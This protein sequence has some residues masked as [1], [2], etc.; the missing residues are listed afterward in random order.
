M[1]A[2]P[3]PSPRRARAGVSLMFFTNGVLLA[4]LLPRFPEIKDALGLSNSA[5][6]LTVVAMPV[7]A[8]VA[9][10]VAAPVIRRLGT[11]RVATLGSVLLAL[12]FLVAGFSPTVA[13][14]VVG[15]ALAGAV[16]ALVDAA[17]NVQGVL[18]ERWRGRSVINSLHA[19]WSLGAATG[20][21]I[22]A[23]AAALGV[24]V[25]LQM[26]VNGVVWSG[27]AVLAA[28]LSRVPDTVRVELDAAD[29]APSAAGGS[30]TPG[31][32]RVWRLLLPLVVLAICGTLV[33]DVA[34]NWAVLFLRRETDA[35]VAVA[36][37]GLTVVLVAQFV[38]RLVGDPMT[39]RWGRAPVARAGG[40]LIAVGAL[41]AA[42]SPAYVAVLVGFAAMGFGSATLV[43]A[44]FAA[45]GRVPGLPEGT[46][47]A[48]LGW[49]MRIGFLVT[50][51]TI[52][53]ISDVG[54]LRVAWGVP[55]VAGLVALGLAHRSARRDR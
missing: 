35:P 11:L 47:I 39:D 36:G 51:P 23:A 30:A 44:A 43:P 45:A 55:V 54:G 12:A 33:E 7:G 9:A 10:G 1:T 20:G 28:V 22:G 19:L 34:N 41:V 53:A 8:L 15:L 48:L 37:L 3:G 27:A 21:A 24:D 49:S 25:V 2:A 4:A 5:F 18:V 16:D 42:V 29:A 46:G 31:R 26:T 38:G 40:V 32:A 14:L 50:S 17:Q 52:G 13:V 6:G